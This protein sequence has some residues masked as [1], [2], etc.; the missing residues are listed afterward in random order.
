MHVGGG[1]RGQE[2]RNADSFWKVERPERGPSLG[3]P[4]SLSCS[5][6]SHLCCMPGA[7]QCRPELRGCE[8]VP[9]VTSCSVGASGDEA[10]WSGVT[11]PEVRKAVS[12][13]SIQT[14]SRQSSGWPWKRNSHPRRGRSLLCPRD[15]PRGSRPGVPRGLWRHRSALRTGPGGDVTACGAE[16]E[17]GRSNKTLGEAPGTKGGHAERWR[18]VSRPPSVL[19]T[20]VPQGACRLMLRGHTPAPSRG[21]GDGRPSP[22]CLRPG[23]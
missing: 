18:W 16:C 15:S 5:P 21:P 8:D 6:Q 12:R 4:R 19:P 13:P 3:P 14:D 20:P 2:P 17:P 1:G 22:I 10:T 7:V 9:E 23:F 11:V